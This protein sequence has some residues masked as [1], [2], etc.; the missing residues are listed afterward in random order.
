MSPF[1]AA[2]WGFPRERVRSLM[3]AFSTLSRGTVAATVAVAVLGVGGTVAAVTQLRSDSND[4]TATVDSKP[5]V[6]KVRLT[7]GADGTVSWRKHAVLQ[8]RHAT[9]A[10]VSLTTKAGEVLIGR[11]SADGSRWRSE[12]SLVPH[13]RYQARVV[14]DPVD[15]PAVTKRVKF[16]TSDA[17][18]HLTAILSP[19]DNDVVGVGSPVIVRLS[20]PVPE[21][22][23]RLVQ[24]RFAVS[25]SPDVVGAWHWMNDQEIHWRPPT[26]W[27][28]GTSVTVSS[29][30]E[31]LYVGHGVWGDGQHR[32][33][34][35]IGDSHVSRVDVARHQMYVY[36][37][38][39][40]VKTFPIS[41]GQDK[42]PT[43]NGVHITFEKA[44]VVTMDSATVGIPRDSPDGYY[45]KVY[46]DV[47][48]S[49]GG[50]F[51]HAA[52]WSVADQ[53]VTNV[54]HGCVNLST[55][56]AQWF[57]NWSQ[58]G[59]IVD[60][61]NSS[62]AVDTA[63]PGMADWNM[64]WKQWVAGDAHP[65][66]AAKALHPNAPRDG[67]PAAPSTESSGGSGGGSGNGSGGGNGHRHNNG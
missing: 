37:N 24:D 21:G 46:W 41:A 59:D 15:G 51:V 45:E 26:Y 53:G 65:T 6:P 33:T 40:L 64:S 62:A 56:N 3:R 57:Y 22:K 30:L 31:D 14:L 32:T 10:D 25:T 28:P 55:E 27:K 23:R 60:V 50:A 9:F 16:R 61:Y 66:A 18:R 58:R 47:R 5:L 7:G 17:K 43:K 34:F 36:D 1:D 35:G 42:Y 8:A 63:D 38:G 44:Q 49:Y 12:H 39:S 52:P 20:R 29:H 2:Q 67:E 4:T 48:I 19:G 54:S 11:M 13:N